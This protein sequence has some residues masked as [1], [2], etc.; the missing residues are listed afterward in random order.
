MPQRYRLRFVYEKKNC[1]V[2]ID[3]LHLKIFGAVLEPVVNPKP[4][5]L[6]VWLQYKWSQFK[7]RSLKGKISVLACTLIFCSTAA[8]MFCAQ[9]YQ[10]S[11]MDLHRTNR[12]FYQY[13]I[14]NEKRAKDYQQLDSLIHNNEFFKIYRTLEH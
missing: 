1:S 10:E 11:V 7:E 5:T 4:P 13:V 2:S 3:T 8:L 6:K 12:I 9:L 14:Q